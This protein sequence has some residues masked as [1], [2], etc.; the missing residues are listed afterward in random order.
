[1]EGLGCFFEV[2]GVFRGYLLTLEWFDLL[3]QLGWFTSLGAFWRGRATTLHILLKGFSD[4]ATEGGFNPWPI[5]NPGDH[6]S[7]SFDTRAF[8]YSK[9]SEETLLQPL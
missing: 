3:C 4:E 8:R 7:C 9:A 1:M 2:W 5:K 6:V